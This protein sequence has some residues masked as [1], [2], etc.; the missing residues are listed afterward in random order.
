MDSEL[1]I[2]IPGLWESREAFLKSVVV[3]TSGE[4]MFAGGVLA[5]PQGNDH[6]EVDF[7]EPYDE[8]ATAFEFGG[9]G[10]I[11]DETLNRIFEHKSVIYLHFPLNIVAQRARL[12]K[13]TN[14]IHRC[15]GLAIKLE[16]SG[17][18]HEWEDWFNFIDSGNPFNLYCASVVLV[19]DENDYFSCGMHNFGLADSQIS[20]QFEVSVAA[21]LLNQFNYWQ[22]LERPNFKSGHTFSLT[23]DSPYFRLILQKD[24]RHSED[25]LFYNPHGIW[26]LESI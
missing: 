18:A 22:I 12:L 10:K 25:D 11:S 21:E 20:R 9:Q 5:H 2:C 24:N 1:I 7:F 13:F 19:A 6:V 4:Y 15:G 3:T 14:V 23:V 16:T 17:I 8:M 26:S